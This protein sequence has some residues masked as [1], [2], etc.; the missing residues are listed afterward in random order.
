ML[1]VLGVGLSK[2]GTTSLAAAVRLLGLKT[3]HYDLVRLMDVLDG[4]EP[5]P[6][7]RRY[8]DV[9]A[10]TDIP[11]AAFYQ[12]IM[13]AYPTCRAVLTVRE[14]EAWWRSIDAHIRRRPLRPP[15]PWPGGPLTFD[16]PAAREWK[17][18]QLMWLSRTLVYG[19][20]EPHEFFYK[21]R[22]VEH[23][24][25]VMAEV[26][27]DRLLVMDISTGDGWGP[28]CEF[29]RLPVPAKPFPILNKA[30]AE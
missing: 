20:S 13:D 24:A 3:V 15:E 1:Q 11:A 9:D 25:R 12:E 5:K 30:P 17:R 28:L 7:F 21:K 23:S 29:L 26:P 6:H 14:C 16:N 18:N 10:V 22:F 4:T 27:R 8:D 19:S 2:T